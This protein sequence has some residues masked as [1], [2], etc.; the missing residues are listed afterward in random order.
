M[1]LNN[2]SCGEVG[3]IVRFRNNPTITIKFKNS[4]EII[5]TDSDIHAIRKSVGE[6]VSDPLRQSNKHFVGGH[7]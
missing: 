2:M 5:Q 4:P 7:V 1:L 3:V 6:G